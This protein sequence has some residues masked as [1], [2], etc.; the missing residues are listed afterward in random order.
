MSRLL[1]IIVVIIIGFVAR[2]ILRGVMKDFS[3][4]ASSAF[5]QGQQQPPQAPPKER[6]TQE[7]IAGELHKDPVCGMYVAE[8]TQY[9]R[10]AGGETFYYCS[11]SCKDKHAVTARA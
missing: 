4:A 6:K 7:K 3:S 2:A 1:D 10:R 5:Q 8:S 9:Q 11:S